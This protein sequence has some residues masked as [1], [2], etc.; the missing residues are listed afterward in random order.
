MREADRDPVAG[1]Q[2][3]LHRAAR[4]ERPEP[5]RKAEVVGIDTGYA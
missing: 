2:P 1:Y 5:V 4:I 3:T